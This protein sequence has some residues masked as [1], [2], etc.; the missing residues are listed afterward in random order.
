MTGG[1]NGENA[2]D[3]EGRGRG[4]PQGTWKPEIVAPRTSSQVVLAEMDFRDL[5]LMGTTGVTPEDRI[6][7][8]TIQGRSNLLP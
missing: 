8:A 4:D 3:D 7:G 1:A 2:E 5:E 6:L